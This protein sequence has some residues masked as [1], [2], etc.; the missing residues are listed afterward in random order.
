M[1]KVILDQG[2]E[3][4]LKWRKERLTATDAAMLLGLSPYA[5]PHKCW[6]RK[7]GQAEE[8]KSSPAMLRGVQDEPIARALFIEEYGINMTPC[9]IESELHPFIGASLDGISDCGQFILEIKSQRPTSQIPEFHMI[10]MQKQLL[11]T[12]N[13]AKKCFYVSH[14]EGKNITTEVFPDPQWMEEYI[15]KAKEFWKRVLFFDSPPLICKDY[16]DMGTHPLWQSY[17][18]EYRNLSAQIKQLEE[19]KDSYKKELIK[20][21][22]QQSSSG[23]GIKV[24]KKIVKG[25]VDYEKMVEELNIADEKI[26]GYRKQSSETWTIMIDKKN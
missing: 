14:W 8:Q 19:I 16:Q 26:N 7:V 10:Q 5:T 9:C 4:W 11:C 12:D 18:R 1:R 24:L 17:A 25:R 22:G 3:E 21:C 15:P 23:D 13:T 6:Q 20:L 2:S